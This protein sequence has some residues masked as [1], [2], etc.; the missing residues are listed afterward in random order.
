MAEIDPKVDEVRLGGG[1]GPAYPY[2]A[3]G[4]AVERAEQLRNANMARQAFPPLAVYKVWGWSGD[5]GNARQTMAALN[6]FGLIEYVG[7]GNNR[8]VKLSP[9][10]HRIVFD[11]VPDSKERALALHEAALL[12]PIYQKLWENYGPD[13]P[14]DVAI[15]TF[16]TRDCAFNEGAAQNVIVG[17]RD[18]LSFAG[19]NKPALAGLIE[20]EASPPE[21]G[22]GS[23]SSSSASTGSSELP[24]QWAG[25]GV[26]R[27]P[28]VLHTLGMPMAAAENDIKILLDGDRLRVSA[29]VDIKG[30]KR[31]L[32]AIKVNLALLEDDD[33]ENMADN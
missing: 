33:D 28:P 10:A 17:Y 8:T 4:K 20:P 15:E 19:L 3:L 1:R 30:A 24:R 5:N 27:Q 26:A 18:T 12:P 13:L 2:I 14:P 6:H 21:S 16:L 25:E 29:Y 7:R 22:E 11:K 23:G 9:L 31:L 32:K